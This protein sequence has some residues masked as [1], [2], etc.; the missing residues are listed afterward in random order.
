MT[1]EEINIK[2]NRLLCKKD[3]EVYNLLIPGREGRFYVDT[4]NGN[5]YIWNGT[6]YI[7][8][9]GGGYTSFSQLSGYSNDGPMGINV[10]GNTPTQI[11]YLALTNIGSEIIGSLSTGEITVSKEDWYTVDFS[12]N[13]LSSP[14]GQLIVTLFVNNVDV[15][16][17]FGY[18]ASLAASGN[19]NI[20]FSR[21]VELQEGDVV[22]VKVSRPLVQGTTN[23]VISS[24]T[25]IVEL[26][27][28]SSSGSGGGG[29]G[30]Q[31]NSDWNSISGPSE[32]L[33]KPSIPVITQVN[34]VTIP[35]ASFSLVS[36]LYEASYSNVSILSTSIINITP[37]NSTISIV[38]AALFL[39]QL[40]VSLGSVKM[41][42]ENLPSGDFD[43]DIV[44]IN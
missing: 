37:R 24:V 11:P 28:G 6:E 22:S 20:S 29:G 33:N 7:T 35:A 3:Y 1:I 32:I 8:G 10:L 42:A 34:L 5:I 40:T 18:S 2:V 17:L 14:G 16:D 4:N 23:L 31:V 36:G 9:S 25:F 30:T 13:F 43:V 38:S 39:P 44:I 19:A 12:M 21:K 41:Y 26:F 15:Y 27:S